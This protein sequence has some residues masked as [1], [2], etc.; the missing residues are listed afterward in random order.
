MTASKLSEWDDF[1]DTLMAVK[2]YWSDMPVSLKIKITLAANFKKL[3]RF[4]ELAMESEDE[5]NELE[6]AAHR[7]VDASFLTLGLDAWVADDPSFGALSCETFIGLETEVDAVQ[8]GHAPEDSDGPK[9]AATK[10]EEVLQ[11]GGGQTA[12]CWLLP[13]SHVSEYVTLSHV[14]QCQSLT[15]TVTTHLTCNL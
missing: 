1:A 10:C 7:F 9:G 2:D 4:S 8:S 11:A 14:S 3:Q 15:I 13:D 5:L 6:S 12:G